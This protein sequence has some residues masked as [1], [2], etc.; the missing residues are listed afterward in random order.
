MYLVICL[1][2]CLAVLGLRCYSGA[3]SSCGNQGL[4]FTVVGAFL[5]AEG[6]SRCGAQALG[7]GGAV[8]AAHGLSCSMA[9][10]IL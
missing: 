5:T 10:T 8:V 7:L 4:L 2:I 9:C 6:F 3:F 1:C